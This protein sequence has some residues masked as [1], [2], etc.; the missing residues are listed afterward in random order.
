MAAAK[1]GVPEECVSSFL[2][3]ISELQRESAKMM[4]TAYVR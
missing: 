2:V 4:S 3:D 1:I